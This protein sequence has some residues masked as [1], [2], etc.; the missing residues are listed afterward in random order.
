MKLLNHL[1]PSLLSAA[2]F[3]F[4]IGACAN[5]REDTDTLGIIACEYFADGPILEATATATAAEAPDVSAQ[6]TRYNLSLANVSGARGGFLKVTLSGGEHTFFFDHAVGLTLTNAGGLVPAAAQLSSDPDCATV[7][8]AFRYDV[9]AGTY[10]LSLTTTA[11]D[12]LLLVVLGP[13]AR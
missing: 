9:S 10:T 4:A 3:A 2:A 1:T 5:D 6:D 13:E 7:K 8:S 12:P 11:E